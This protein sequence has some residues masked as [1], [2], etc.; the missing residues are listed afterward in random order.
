M[1]QPITSSRNPRPWPNGSPY[2]SLLPVQNL[3]PS[4]IG[5]SP[6]GLPTA[7]LSPFGEHFLSPIDVPRTY[8]ISFSP[9]TSEVDMIPILQ[10]WK[11]KP[12][13]VRLQGQRELFAR[14]HTTLGCT[15]GKE[16]Q[17]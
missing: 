7:S 12:G 4:T 16:A 13:F 8:T 17:K 9:T 11:P 10:M 5:N 6:S 14:L 15:L 3:G 2:Y 1:P